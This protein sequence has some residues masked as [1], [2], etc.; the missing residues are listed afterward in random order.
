MLSLVLSLGMVSAFPASIL[1]P[2]C[3]SFGRESTSSKPFVSGATIKASVCARAPCEV[4]TTLQSATKSSRKHG[5][6][7][8][9][10]TGR[11]PV[12]N[13][14][15]RLRPWNGNPIAH[16]ALNIDNQKLYKQEHLLLSQKTC[17]LVEFSRSGTLSCFQR[18]LKQL[19]TKH[20]RPSST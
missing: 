5:L 10:Q 7:L 17:R 13:P 8:I 16:F 19:S 9:Y 12:R 6:R 4:V 14:S 2:P 20:S 1:P 3:S 15:P 11:S 18:I